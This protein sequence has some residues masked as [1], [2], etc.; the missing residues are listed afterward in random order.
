MIEDYTFG[1]ILVDGILY[2]SDI[3]INDGIVV[4]GW[5]RKSGHVVTIEDIGDILDAGADILVIGS[6]DPG[7]MKS[8]DPLRAYLKEAHIKLIE[9]STSKAVLTFNKLFDKGEKVA[10]GFHLTC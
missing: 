1:K 5:W 9:E 8:S 4:P 10:A 3:K 6:G 7:L 2:T